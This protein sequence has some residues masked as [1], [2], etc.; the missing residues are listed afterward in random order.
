MI[1]L[2]K[3]EETTDPTVKKEHFAIEFE[4]QI[5]AKDT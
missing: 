4:A 2:L 3:K 1:D 5:L